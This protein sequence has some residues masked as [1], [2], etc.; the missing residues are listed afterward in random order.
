M[1]GQTLLLSLFLGSCAITALTLFWL[2][3]VYSSQF[4]SLCSTSVFHCFLVVTG[5]NV[6]LGF[7]SFRLWR[8]ARRLHKHKTKERAT[9][10][11]DVFRYQQLR[12]PPN[13][14]T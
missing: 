9:N 1:R 11:R 5:F 2:G 7:I 3:Y 10:V 14:D 13:M 12:H 8:Q 6:F 4:A